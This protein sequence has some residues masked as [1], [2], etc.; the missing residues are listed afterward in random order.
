[1]H[2]QVI[3]LILDDCKLRVTQSVFMDDIKSILSGF[4]NNFLKLLI[5]DLPK[6][7]LVK[8]EPVNEQNGENIARTFSPNWLIN[9]VTEGY[10][11]SSKCSTLTEAQVLITID[12]YVKKQNEGISV[13]SHNTNWVCKFCSIKTDMPTCKNNKR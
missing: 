5:F 10:A 4:D 1:M 11:I 13:V 7:G 2:L 9:E 6:N 12:G 3:F 8:A